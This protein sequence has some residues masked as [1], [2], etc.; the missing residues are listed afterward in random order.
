MTI[1]GDELCERLASIAESYDGVC[2]CAAHRARFEQ[3]L[4]PCRPS[5]GWDWRPFSLA[6][7]EGMSTC[8]LFG[9]AVEDL[10]GLDV[11]WHGKAYTPKAEVEQSVARNEQWARLAK[12]WQTFSPGLLPARGNVLT[13]TAGLAT[14]EL[15]VVG[16]SDAGALLSVDGGQTCKL[17]GDG[18]EG[19]GRQAIHRRERE[20]RER[21]GKAYLWDRDMGERLV[22]GWVVTELAPLRPP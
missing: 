3:L 8:G 6:R 15:V 14:H 2:A 11:P 16:W 7:K 20:W 5:R 21:G 22:H 10:A 12:C 18:H 19:I 17:R 1:G 4:A 9:E 13:L